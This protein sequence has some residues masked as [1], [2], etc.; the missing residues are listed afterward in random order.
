MLAGYESVQA[1]SEVIGNEAQL[2]LAPRLPVLGWIFKGKVPATHNATDARW[3]KW[4]TLI[5]QQV[6]I[7]N[8]SLPGILEVIVNWPEC[9]N[10]GLSSSS[11]E[12]KVTHVEEAPP[13]NQLLENEKQHSLITDSS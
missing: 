7:E 12:E 8:L 5:T 11:E 9:K 6:Q 13:Y 10:F 3:S 1:T 2:L 4:V